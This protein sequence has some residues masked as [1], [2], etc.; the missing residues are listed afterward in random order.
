MDFLWSKERAWELGESVYSVNSSPLLGR[1]GDGRW[2]EERSPEPWL[3][4]VNCA[5]IVL[6]SK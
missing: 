2:E 1:L 3:S 5:V 4:A 6:A